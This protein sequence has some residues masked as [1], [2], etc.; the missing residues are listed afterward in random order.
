MPRT[1][2]PYPLE[3]RERMVELV[4]SGRSPES[5]ANEF[6]PAAGSI[7]VWVRQADTDEGRREGMTTSER[8]ELVRLRRDNRILREEKEILAT[9]AAW[10]AEE[11]VP[12]PRRRS[13]S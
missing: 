5:L 1:R 9:A 6:E 2:P 8:A 7:R 3:F 11:A 10:V 12:T 13:G 4:R